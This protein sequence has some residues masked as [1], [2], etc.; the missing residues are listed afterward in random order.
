MLAPCRLYF[1]NCDYSGGRPLDRGLLGRCARLGRGFSFGFPFAHR[2]THSLIASNVFRD[3]EPGHGGLDH[4][5]SE[6]L[7]RLETQAALSHVQLPAA[8]SVLLL[9]P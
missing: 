3:R 2:V 9:E 7:Q 8:L 4:I 1:S 5:E 6:V